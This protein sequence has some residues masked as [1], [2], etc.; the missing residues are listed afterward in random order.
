MAIFFV[1]NVSYYF[2]LKAAD[3]ASSSENIFGNFYSGIFYHCGYKSTWNT[4]NLHF[5]SRFSTG[6]NVQDSITLTVILFIPF[7]PDEIKGSKKSVGVSVIWAVA[8]TER[9]L[10]NGVREG[11]GIEA[12]QVNMRE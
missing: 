2:S 6:P 8:S 4:K 1:G 10:Q 3:F 7:W 5:F 11:D 12:S 9:E